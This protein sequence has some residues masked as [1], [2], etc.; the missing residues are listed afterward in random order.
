LDT[1]VALKE[2]YKTDSMDGVF[3][4]IARNKE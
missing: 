2:Q 3:L 1:P 4:K